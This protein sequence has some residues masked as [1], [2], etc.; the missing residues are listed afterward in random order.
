MNRKLFLAFIMTIAFVIM[1]AFVVSAEGTSKVTLNDET[2]VDLFDDDGN[3]L[4]WYLDTNNTL[5]SIR[6]DNAVYT[7]TVKVNNTTEFATYTFDGTVVVYG[8]CDGNTMER[9][10]IIENGTEIPATQIVVFNI[11]DDDI[12][13]GGLFDADG[14]FNTIY[15]IHNASNGNG[16]TNLEYAYLG[17]NIEYIIDNS[18]LNCSKLKYVNFEDLTDLV[19]IG[20]NGKESRVFM[21]CKA[22]FA[23]QTL[24]LSNHTKLVNIYGTSNFVGTGFNQI[25]LPPNIANI[26]NL[27]FNN[28]SIESI[29]WPQT[30]THIGDQVLSW[31]KSLTTVTLPSEIVSMRYDAFTES[32]NLSTIYYCGTRDQFIT[33]LGNIRI[34]SWENSG[35]IYACI[36]TYYKDAFWPVV[37]ASTQDDA[38]ALHE[39]LIAIKGHPEAEDIGNL[40]SYAD[41][42]LLTDEQ[43]SGNKYVVYDYN[44]CEAYRDGIHEA[45]DSADDCTKDA[46]C[47]ICELENAVKAFATHNYAEFLTYENG[48]AEAG[49]YS[50]V[51]QNAEFCTCGN[52]YE[53]KFP[54]FEAPKGFSTKG[55]DGIAGG[56]TININAVNEYKRINGSLTIGIMVVNP[57]FLDGK[58]SFLDASGKINTTG[59][60]LQVDMTENEYKNISISLTGLVGNAENVSL[61]IALYAYDEV[62]NVEFI[63]SNT[64]K[65]A[66]KNVTL[67]EQTLYTVTLA[68]V[69]S[70]SSDLSS[71]GDYIMP[72]DKEKQA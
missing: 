37:G 49:K 23:G 44:Y 16:G 9:V 48:Y 67:G 36:E 31:C 61:V 22:L 21:G 3:A 40:I 38:K 25:K 7:S 15:E 72:S 27:T 32:K 64:T 43:K 58:E 55:E 18:F 57:S 52:A 46:D 8:F 20:R 13:D 35:N 60:A 26:G 62:E 66:D 17:T 2:E 6:A 41:Y 11:M 54:L 10:K 65:C 53:N 12:T 70:A 47:K 1:L 30:I 56:Y 28:S 33:F 51:C 39:S 69:K 50:Y 4:I 14:T 29:V 59:G 5:K 63:Q 42:K 34:N 19:S 68:S 71:L 24:D 45:V